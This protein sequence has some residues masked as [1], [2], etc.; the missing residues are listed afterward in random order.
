MV[1]GELEVLRDGGRDGQAVLVAERGSTA[2][3]CS[4][5]DEGWD[6]GNGRAGICGDRRRSVCWVAWEAAQGGGMGADVQQ[7]DGDGD[8]GGGGGVGESEQI[9]DGMAG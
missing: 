9:E 8:Q 3:V 1:L 4:A 2:S 6:L 7:R 5:T